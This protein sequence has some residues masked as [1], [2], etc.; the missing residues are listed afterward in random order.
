MNQSSFAISNS[1]SMLLNKCFFLF[2]YLSMDLFSDRDP[3]NSSITHDNIL[4]DGNST[5]V[6]N[7]FFHCDH[8]QHDPLLLKRLEMY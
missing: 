3:E 7:L 6:A 1:C 4:V 5:N 2:D 8:I